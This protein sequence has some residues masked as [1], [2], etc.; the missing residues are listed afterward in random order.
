MAFGA[1]LA[2][3]RVTPSSLTRSGFRGFVGGRGIGFFTP[4]HSGTSGTSA[5]ASA[6]ASSKVR[7]NINSSAGGQSVS[8]WCPLAVSFVH[9]TSASTASKHL[10][11]NAGIAQ[12]HLYKK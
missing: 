10:K 9:A 3:P 2:A 12:W 11:I 5:S 1:L 6:S 7:F 8:S 4:I